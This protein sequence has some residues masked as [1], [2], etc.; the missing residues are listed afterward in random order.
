MKVV[1]KFCLNLDHR[2]QEIAMPKSAVPHLIAMQAFLVCMWAVVETGAPITKRRFI[3]AA[4]GQV[5]DGRHVGSCLD[6]AFVWHVFELE[7]DG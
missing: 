1:H 6:R 7:G 5:V 3:V 2:P 4:T